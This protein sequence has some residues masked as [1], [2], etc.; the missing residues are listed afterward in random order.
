MPLADW[1]NFGKVGFLTVYL[2][3]TERKRENLDDSWLF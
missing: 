3:Q 1:I 2:L